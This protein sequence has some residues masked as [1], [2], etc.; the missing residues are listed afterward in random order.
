MPHAYYQVLAMLSEAPGRTLRMSELAR[1]TTSSPSRLSHAVS[2][3]EERGWVRRDKHPSDRRGALAV[4]TDDGFDVLAAAAPGH[5]AA[6]REALFD[7]L[8]DE[9][10]TAL[11]EIFEQL[12]QEGPGTAG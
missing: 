3:L 1:I 8:D 6:V 11:R 10:V 2:R 9:Q 7:R 5:V 12:T 4:L